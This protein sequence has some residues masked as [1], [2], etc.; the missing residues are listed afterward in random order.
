M[1]PDKSGGLIDRLLLE[2]SLE[3]SLVVD[4]NI[5]GETG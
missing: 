2:K 3:A 4:F 1:Y 5:N